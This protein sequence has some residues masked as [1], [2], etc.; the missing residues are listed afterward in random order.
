MKWVLCLLLAAV[1]SC[2][3]AGHAHIEKVYQDKW[4]SEHGGVTEYRLDDLARVDCL[5]DEYSVEFDFGKKWAESV[6]QSLFYAE[7]TGKRPGVVLILESADDD[8]F[9]K[10][11]I[12]VT[13]RYGITTWTM[14]PE[15]LCEF[16]EPSVLPRVFHRFHLSTSVFESPINIFLTPH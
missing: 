3:Y 5:T 2:L 15:S 7:K 13:A 16:H 10:R 6:G 4:C 9:L 14:T 11:L 1:P 12:T 8:R